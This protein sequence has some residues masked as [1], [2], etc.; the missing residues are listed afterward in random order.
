MVEN[1]TEPGGCLLRPRVLV[2]NVLHVDR[3]YGCNL[4]GAGSPSRTRGVIL[5]LRYAVRA[6]SAFAISLGPAPVLRLILPSRMTHTAPFKDSASLPP[7]GWSE[8]Q[9]GSFAA[10]RHSPLIVGC[11]EGCVVFAGYSLDDR[12]PRFAS[13][14]SP[15]AV[16]EPSGKAIF[17]ATVSRSGLSGAK[18]G[19]F[20]WRGVHNG[21]AG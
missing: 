5:W 4:N 8:P 20:Q 9:A 18:G 14:R 10:T 15:L 13:R 3:D 21:L 17:A 1:S 7:S 16:M 19:N 12:R 2:G 6:L 11:I